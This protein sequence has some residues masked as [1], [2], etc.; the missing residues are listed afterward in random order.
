[1]NEFEYFGP[2]K[3]FDILQLWI[4]HSQKWLQDT[5]SQ[6][7]HTLFFLWWCLI[8]NSVYE[9]ISWQ[10]PW[11]TEWNLF[12]MVWWYKFLQ[13][14]AKNESMVGS[15]SGQSLLPDIST[16]RGA[17]RGAKGG[18]TASLNTTGVH[19]SRVSRSQ[20]MILHGM[21]L[22]ITQQAWWWI[23]GKFLKH[24]VVLR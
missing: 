16:P 21:Y 13:A 23:T 6:G 2:C 22:H 19:C 5:F 15:P 11:S 9:R 24:C 3:R 17:P 20:P 4:I 14:P 1:M 18:G 8:L 10:F 7:V 12:I